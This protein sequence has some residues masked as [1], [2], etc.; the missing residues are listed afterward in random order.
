MTDLV[1]THQALGTT[2]W[3]EIF[4]VL[5]PEMRAVVYDDCS[6][7]LNQFEQTYS[8]FNPN[9]II[10]KLNRDRYIDHPSPECYDLLQ[11]GHRLYARSQG[12]FNMLVGDTLINRGYD[13]QY[14]FTPTGLVDSIPNVHDALVI[15]RERITVSSGSIDIGGFGKGYAIDILVARLRE[16]YAIDEF[17]I[18]GGGDMYGTSQQGKPITIYLEHPLTLNSAIGT[19]TIFNQGFA[20]SSPHKRSWTYE[21]KIHSHIVHVSPQSLSRLA[22]STP[23]AVFVKALRAAD[24]DAFATV[25]LVTSE[26]EMLVIASSEHLGIA[27]FTATANSLKTNGA[28]TSR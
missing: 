26:P 24:A 22:E 17:L 20:A 14:S 18:N 9:S 11:Y 12:Q 23:D 15:N 21:G 5:S 19:T 16:Q 6:H 25:G 28:F 2:W 4:D 7:F 27:L 13:A 1:F 10:S 3:I 8:R